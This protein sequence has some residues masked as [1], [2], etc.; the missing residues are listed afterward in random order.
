MVKRTTSSQPDWLTSGQLELKWRWQAEA[1][2]IPIEGASLAIARLVEEQK[3]LARA[4][5]QPETATEATP[6][7]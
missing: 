4:T 6:I 3:L 2:S 5:T 7:R 1:E